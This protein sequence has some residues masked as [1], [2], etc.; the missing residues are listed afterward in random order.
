MKANALLPLTNK[1]KSFK[2]IT[3]TFLPKCLTWK[4]CTEKFLLRFFFLCPLPSPCWGSKENGLGKI[5]ITVTGPH[6]RN[7]RPKWLLLHRKF[8][9]YTCGRL[10]HVQYIFGNFWRLTHA[11]PRRRQNQQHT[12]KA[13][14]R[15]RKWS[16]L[17]VCKCQKNI[18]ST[19]CTERSEERRVGKECRSRWSPYH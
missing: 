16:G 4:C 1:K 3:N 7:T 19:N 14:N 13:T 15:E 6:W 10:Y 8:L 9:I 12:L 5:P 17:S 11:A 2:I 18:N